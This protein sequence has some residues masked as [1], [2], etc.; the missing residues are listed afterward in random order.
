MA[1][2]DF[3]SF[4]EGRRLAEKD[5]RTDE[6]H[7][8]DMLDKQQSYD[9]REQA[10]ANTERDQAYK[11][12]QQGY[13]LTDMQTKADD[14][15]AM[16][17]VGDSYAIAQ[18]AAQA[19]GKSIVQVLIES[20][21]FE[22]Q[23]A[24]Q[25]TQSTFQAGWRD[26]LQ[27]SI[28]PALRVKGDTEAINQLSAKFGLIDQSG[29]DRAREAG[30]PELMAERVSKTFGAVQNPNGTFTI[31]GKEFPLTE[32]WAQSY[33]LGSSVGATAINIGKQD[34]VNTANAALQAQIAETAARERA[35]RE[36]AYVQNHVSAGGNREQLP[37]HLQ[38]IYDT[39]YPNGLPT[40][41]SGATAAKPIIDVNAATSQPTMP[42]TPGVSPT[43]SSVKGSSAAVLPPAAANL[44]S[45]S[46][47][48]L[49]NLR[50]RLM[51]EKNVPGLSA[52]EILSITQRVNELVQYR[53][54]PSYVRSM[55]R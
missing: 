54:T 30:S 40:A 24:N 7:W 11:E 17:L 26:V 25:R 48:E 51:T 37:S 2:I 46:T 5:N 55:P 15:E 19:Q 13:Q 6:N 32:A 12:Q 23:G 33:N 35:T 45:M 4:I 27:K 21:M 20:P 34:T 10:Y 8:R 53:Q 3:M 18:K 50:N 41:A 14:T 16:R 47:V 9:I 36:Y 52:A 29:I 44:D 42:V 31:A 1:G 49:I 43:G 28:I 22:L 39:K 38:G